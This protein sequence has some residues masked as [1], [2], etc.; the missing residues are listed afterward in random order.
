MRSPLSR[1]E[2][3]PPRARATTHSRHVSPDDR[4]SQG[5]NRFPR[6]RPGPARLCAAVFR[7]GAGNLDREPSPVRRGQGEV[8]AVFRRGAASP[9]HAFGSALYWSRGRHL[10]P[11]LLLTGEGFPAL[12]VA[13]RGAL[14]PAPYP[15]I[16]PK[17]A[18][19]RVASRSWLSSFRRLMR[20]AGSG[21]LTVTWS[22]KASTA[23]RNSASAA[24]APS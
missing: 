23:G 8:Y 13:R 11:A 7:R 9:P 17:S 24:I 3:W 15:A 4:T 19:A 16:R 10:I 2:N 6:A 5:G 14:F 21:S 22:K 20:S 12:F 1:P 18:T